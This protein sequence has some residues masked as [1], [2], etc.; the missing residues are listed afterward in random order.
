MSTLQAVL[1]RRAQIVHVD[2]E[3]A[4]GPAAGD[5]RTAAGLTAL[6]AEL[7]AR[8]HAL[9]EPLRSVLAG[10]GPE[11]LADTGRSLLRALDAQLGADRTHMPLFRDFPA[12]VPHDTLAL[13]VDRV[14]A[15]LLQQPD[16]P[17]VLCGTVGR[18]HPVAPCA[19]L[20]CRSCWDGADYAGCPLCHRR[21]D[22]DDPFLRPSRQVPPPGASSQGPLK[23]LV[24]GTSRTADAA[25]ELA[26]L[27]ARATPLS[28]QDRDDLKVL[29][30]HA[31]PGGLTWLPQDVPVRETKALVLGTL[32]RDGGPATVAAV[33]EL[34]PLRL[35]TATDVL[36]LLCV[37]SGG[38]A[39]LLQPPRQRGLPR[40][41]R[42]ELLGVLDAF[43]TASLVEDLLRH[44]AAWLRAAELLHPFE[45]H[46][47]HPRAALAFA[48]LRSTDVSGAGPLA[49]ALSVTAQR[50][51]QA[52]A[53]RA[54][55]DGR[56]R[57]VPRTWAGRIEEA[58]RAG[59]PAAAVALLRQRP[60]ELVR[61]LDHVL[62]LYGGGEL[63]PAVAEALEEGLPRVGP[64]ALLGA[65]GA[66]RGR[67]VPSARRV[68]FPRGA[69]TR[70]HA[71]EDLREPLAAPVVERVCA[72]LEAEALR[73][74]S[75]AP[76]FEVALLDSGLAALA[77]PFAEHSAAASLVAVPRG[78]TLDLPEGDVLRLFLHWMEPE[79]ARVD[80]D[81]SVA[82]FDEEWNGV[83]LCDYTKLRFR[84][85][86][87]VHSGDLT[88]APAPDGATEYVDLDVLALLEADVRYAVPVVFS[89][90]NI[91]FEELPDAFA[92][93][94]T[95]PGTGAR[96]AAYDPRTV[97]QR[98]D[99]T[100]RSRACVP[101]VVDLAEG[102]ALWTDV[103]LPGD[104]GLHSVGRHGNAMGALGRELTGYFSGGARLSLWELC[105][106]HAAAR[107]GEV[108]V[109]RRV[110][111]GAAELWRYGRREGEGAGAF[112][113]RLRAPA[114]PDFCEP[115]GDA[116]ELAAAAVEGR[117]AFVALLEGAVGVRK[118]T[119][120]VYRLLP[121]AVDGCEGT[122]RVTAGGL[123][124]ALA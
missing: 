120:T 16:Q 104:S 88:S 22:R 111:G 3:P 66:L 117:H 46:A 87:A 75:A 24:L 79:G 74:L 70:V 99:L 90:N 21:I 5:A 43:D 116:H 93:F 59:D 44:R 92:G 65:L 50:H 26:A 118:A 73:R 34:L 31:G 6:E 17:C 97:R 94:M 89:Y 52:V 53:V 54:A 47:R 7:L 105:C 95:L 103:H 29:L 114:P 91:P 15:L 61:R 10:A 39:D 41:L 82:F 57:I 56:A 108:A 33:R 30:A 77:V 48:A 122:V 38:E 98:F 85:D 60:G 119:G 36:R 64:G 81:L 100:G 107:A 113:A 35:T 12:S 51:P 18:V 84:H 101:M 72:L 27:L 2:H 110:P 109:I 37:W 23:L 55:A 4:T 78:S 63:A 45:Q 112:A 1:L 58:L 68:F 69:V 62:R 67:H 106:W 9:T 124:S 13:Y 49:R 96:G 71:V 19:H 32:L 102:R 121:G 40:P 25:R 86:A 76:P 80:L 115:V 8:G 20:V 11:A 83:G 123:L 14:F 42:R 28:P